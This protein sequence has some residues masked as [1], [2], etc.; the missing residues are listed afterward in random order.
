M[1]ALMYRG[2]RFVG[3]L[4]NIVHNEVCM[5]NVIPTP[6]LNS[7]GGLISGTPGGLDV[8]RAVIPFE[9]YNIK[10]EKI[11]IYD[12]IE[13]PI[14][15]WNDLTQ[16]PDDDYG[17][18]IIVVQPK[19]VEA[20]IVYCD[21]IPW[22]DTEISGELWVPGGDFR[23]ILNTRDMSG[24]GSKDNPFKNLTYALEAISCYMTMV[25]YCY[26][27]Q[28]FI[29]IKLT[30][31]VNYKVADYSG[32][33]KRFGTEL[34]NLVIDGGAYDLDIKTEPYPAPR[35][36]SSQIYGYARIHNATINLKGHSNHAC[37]FIDA[38]I[39]DVKRKFNLVNCNIT[40][41]EHVPYEAYNESLGN[42]KAY[43]CSINC[44]WAYSMS[45]GS[46][47]SRYS[48]Y[49]DCTIKATSE[50]S[51]TCDILTNSILYLKEEVAEW[52]IE[53]NLICN[54]VTECYIEA[55]NVD[56]Y[57]KVCHNTIYSQSNCRI[58]EFGFDCIIS[59]KGDLNLDVIYSSEIS[60]TGTGI[61]L[62]S[63]LVDTSITAT[64]TDMYVRARWDRVINSNITIDISSER[65]RLDCT[66]IRL[67]SGGYAE[68]SEVSLNIKSQCAAIA[69]AWYLP[70]GATCK[71]CNGIISI[72]APYV[73]VACGFAGKGTIINCSGT[74]ICENNYTGASDNGCVIVDESF[75]DSTNNPHFPCLSV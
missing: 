21:S 33:F 19:E 32:L 5:G 39:K 35:Q 75:C 71:N 63:V 70:E 57:G 36:N 6:L 67:T 30:G 16:S 38:D 74:Y 12:Y 59:S 11:T 60:H 10:K 54:A 8:T 73:R 3:N 69:S 23:E 43:K 26:D 45:G 55:Y 9:Y 66:D 20:Y 13:N 31:I 40:V 41:G 28:P 27:C 1:G 25:D 34:L 49:S 42:V 37:I 14:P 53:A 24:D 17:K 68:N 61:N 50:F 56:I 44:N 48:V 64:I 47:S 58:A 52:Y 2:I 18:D 15:E 51:L 29:C 7:T 4:L 65:K 72:D 46:L 62:G 22:N